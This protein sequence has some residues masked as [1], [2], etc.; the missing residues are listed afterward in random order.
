MSNHYIIKIIYDISHLVQ[1]FR[2]RL[3][4]LPG[5]ELHERKVFAGDYPNGPQL[6]VAVECIP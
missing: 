5:G 1:L 4:R 3:R 2:R 6:P